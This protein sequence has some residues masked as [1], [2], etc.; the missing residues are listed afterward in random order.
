MSAVHKAFLVDRV[1]PDVDSHVFLEML[2]KKFRW[3][4]DEFT[5]LARYNS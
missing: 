1:H 2:L 3:L 5:E 4:T